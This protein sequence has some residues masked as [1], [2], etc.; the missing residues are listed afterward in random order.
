MAMLPGG[1][2][3]YPGASNRHRFLTQVYLLQVFERD[4]Q[5]RFIVSVCHWFPSQ[6]RPELSVVV[7]MVAAGPGPRVFRRRTD[8]VVRGTC[9]EP[10]PRTS[11]A[12]ARTAG[13]RPVT[14]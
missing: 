10:A 1:V 2:W 12:P 3:R 13:R 4:F 5:R 8:Q 14:R 11:E 6:R 9:A 7:A